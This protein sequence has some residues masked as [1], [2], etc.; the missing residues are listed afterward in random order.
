MRFSRFTVLNL[1]LVFGQL[2]SCRAFAKH[3]QRK[4]FSC[5]V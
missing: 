3:G 5:D 1:A 4:L 2:D